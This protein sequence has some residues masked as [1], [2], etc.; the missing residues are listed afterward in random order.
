MNSCNYLNILLLTS[1]AFLIIANTLLFLKLR[2]LKSIH[3]GNIPL[4]PEIIIYL[5]DLAKRN[6]ATYDET[7][8][9]AVAFGLNIME[10]RSKRSIF[11]RDECITDKNE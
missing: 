9:H 11:E 4:S 6:D 8:A 3:C 2:K 7:F 5:N 1:A 10:A